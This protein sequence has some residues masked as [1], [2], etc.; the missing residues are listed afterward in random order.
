MRGEVQGLSSPTAVDAWCPGR[1]AICPRRPGGNDR[2]AREFQCRGTDRVRTGGTFV[3]AAHARGQRLVGHHSACVL[4][5][6]RCAGAA[7]GPQVLIAPRLTTETAS[8][9]AEYRRLRSR[10][11]RRKSIASHAFSAST[12]LAR[13]A[14]VCGRRSGVSPSHDT[15]AFRLWRRDWKGEPHGCPNTHRAL[16]PDVAPVRLDDAA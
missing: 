2:G 12:C 9:A 6:T 8:A 11:R 14:F 1:D 5:G 7:H 13:P 4:S 10:S 16:D 3:R 15:S